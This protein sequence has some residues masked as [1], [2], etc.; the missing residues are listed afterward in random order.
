MDKIIE[1]GWLGLRTFCAV[2]LPAGAAL[3][4]IFIAGALWPATGS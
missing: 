4:L 3:G 1:A 2:L